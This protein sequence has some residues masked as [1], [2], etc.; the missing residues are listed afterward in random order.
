MRPT[1]QTVVKNM[2]DGIIT[3][4]DGSSPRNAVQI[5]VDEGDMSFDVVQRESVVIMD[6][7]ELN[8]LRKGKAKP[9]SGKFQVKFKEF[10]SASNYPV[11]PHEA[12]FGVGAAGRGSPRTTTAATCGPSASGSPASRRWPANRPRTSC[13]RNA[14]TSRKRSARSSMPTCLAIDFKDFEERPTIAKGP[15]R[16]RRTSR[17]TARR[18]S[19]APPRRR[20]R[21]NSPLR[22]RRAQRR[23]S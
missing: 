19:R 22:A 18:W 15:G 12:L 21:R 4:E 2:A 8:S 17:P 6:R 13:S 16:P 5:V 10:L 11:T 1:K 3:I 7:M 20:R 23:S 9:C 14:T